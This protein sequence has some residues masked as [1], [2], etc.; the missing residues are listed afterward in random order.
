[1]KLSIKKMVTVDAKILSIHMK[2]CDE[3]C[4]EVISSDGSI[5]GS[6]ENV[7]V[8][9]FMPNG[10]TGETGCS[11][12]GDYLILD[13]DMDTGLVTNWKTPKADQIERFIEGTNR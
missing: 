10:K 5:L 1:M 11:H 12:Y 9:D 7:Y 8:P 3:F 4:A 6:V 2:V 13:I